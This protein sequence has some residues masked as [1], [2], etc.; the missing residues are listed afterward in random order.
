MSKQLCGRPSQSTRVQQGAELHHPG[1]PCA[2]LR[3]QKAK[4]D[5]GALRMRGNAEA[6]N[7][8]AWSSET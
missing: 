4:E 7:S 8:A 5:C 3:Q 1:H 6:P 2:L